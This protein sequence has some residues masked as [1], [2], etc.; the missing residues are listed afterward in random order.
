MNIITRPLYLQPIHRPVLNIACTR[1]H[2]LNLERATMFK[3]Q[4]DIDFLKHGELDRQMKK[5]K[6]LRQERLYYEEASYLFK[7]NYNIIY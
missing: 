7:T 2:I 1:K 3:L 6:Q 4:N 5:V